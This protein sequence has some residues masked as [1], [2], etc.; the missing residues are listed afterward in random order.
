MAAAAFELER[1][2]VADPA[3]GAAGERNVSLRM[4]GMLS[5]SGWG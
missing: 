5:A 2:G 4:L 3:W 1:Q